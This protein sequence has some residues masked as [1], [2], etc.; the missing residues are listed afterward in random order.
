MKFSDI[1]GLE[2]EKK[3]LVQ[4]VEENRIS[5]AQLFLGREGSGN[6][7]LALA[8]AQYINCR[9]KKDGDSCGTCPSC[10]K[11]EKLIH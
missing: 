3:R 8:Y 10:I 7:A 2:E 6:L 5:H 9:N 11:Y 1:Y 4:T